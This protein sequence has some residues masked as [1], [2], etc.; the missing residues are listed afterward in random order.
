MSR[1]NFLIKFFGRHF[2]LFLILVAFISYGQMLFMQ[3]WQDDNALFFKLAHID[4]GAGYFGKGPIGNGLT[5]WAHTPFIPIYIFFGH[6]TVAYF[7]FL[8][9]LYIISAI[10]VY[11]NFSVILGETGGRV[12]GFL[13]GAGYIF[14]DGVWRMANSVTT[15]LS[16]IFISVFLI[17]Y[18]KFYKNKNIIWYFL[19]LFSFFLA[20]EVTI[21]RTHYFFLIVLFFEIILHFQKNIPHFLFGLILRLAPFFYIFQKL[22]LTASS[23]RSGEAQNFVFSFF[24]G[25]FHT[26]YGF[27]S[28]IANLI[29]PDWLTNYLL[30]IQSWLDSFFFSHVPFLRSVLLIIPSIIIVLIFHKHSKK[31]LLI[32]VFLLINT[33]WVFIF[34]ELFISPLFTPTIEQHFIAGLGGTLVLIG[35]SVLIVLREQGRVFLL[36]VLWMLTNIAVYSAYNPTFQY[37]T[38]ERYL[39]HSFVALVG[40]LGLLFVLLPK[41]VL[42]KIGKLLIIAFGIGN[43]VN[44]V[45]YQNN[46]LHARS[47]PAR[48]FYADLK[49][50]MPTLNKGEI[51]YFDVARD[52][53]RYY[54]DAVST[55][56]MPE[57]TAFAWRYGIDR[58]DIKLTTDFNELLKIITADNIS[59]ENIKTFW[60]SKEG[61][62]DTSSSVVMFLSDTQK[63]QDL[64]LD[65][66]QVSETVMRK[67]QI[68]TVWEQP[69][70]EIKPTETLGSITPLEIKLEMTANAFAG[71]IDYPLTLEGAN[72][73]EEQRQ[74]WGNSLLRKLSLE[75]RKEKE[76]L[77]AN[78]KYSVSS[79]W[80]NNVVENLFDGDI[81]SLWQSER[82]GWGQEFTFIEVDL[83]ATQEIEKV[84]W[85]NGFSS[86]TPVGYYIEASLDS[87]NW[88]EVVRINNPKRL[89][90]REEQV[91]SFSPTR[92]K[93]LRMVLTK[94]LNG[95]SPVIAEF[96]VVPAKFSNL[97]IR[98][99]EQFLAK[100]FAFVPD[101]KSFINTL[102]IL[103]EQGRAQLFWEGDKEH[104][105]QTTKQAEFDIIYN[106]RPRFYKI[107][108]P[109]GGSRI[110]KIKISNIVIPSSIFFNSLTARYPSAKEL[111][112][113]D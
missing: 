106:S 36:L 2:I 73:T 47:F 84:V 52:A 18:W 21:V 78:S 109:A 19:A 75:Y 51:L 43:L 35:I 62:K 45:I 39:A 56:Q 66:S 42:G 70:I 81:R 32:P 15:S 112:G 57:T 5:K 102:N 53:Q 38:V 17:G 7:G 1:I 108:I 99:A 61:L 10:F 101:E 64:T 24:R 23:S 20:S 104:G 6:N 76:Y 9:V 34:K 58:Y 82:T 63:V 74:F 8:L 86:N 12:A 96:W 4:E 11:K 87:K 105:W 44:A 22:A 54:N 93:Y 92:V 37:T 85:I 94:T 103:N 79:Q 59:L 91:I 30:V 41:T 14:S 25:E 88:Q 40:I 3:P 31:K 13:Y 49:G 95:D 29:I 83:P 26:Y 89:D 28:T 80:Q 33:S 48:Q 97:D 90:G 46:I 60:Y 50:L 107:N 113:V 55:A 71:R 27:L 77:R 16:I 65:L 111:Y 68:G 100:P 69:E 98:L 72:L 110:S 67:G